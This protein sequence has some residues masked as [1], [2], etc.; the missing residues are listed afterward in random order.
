MSSN[1]RMIGI[2]YRL[3]TIN[4]EE[5]HR[6][7]PFQFNTQTALRKPSLYAKPLNN[8]KIFVFLFRQHI[9]SLDKQHCEGN[10]RTSLVWINNTV[11]VESANR[12]ALS[13]WIN[14][15]VTRPTGYLSK[16]RSRRIF[17]SLLAEVILLA[18]SAKRDVTSYYTQHIERRVVYD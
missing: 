4:R 6:I 14:S 13:V 7:N 15:T 8:L 10:R 12:E 9:F 16:S 18:F 17:K 1:P 5:G 11:A 3:A 2:Q